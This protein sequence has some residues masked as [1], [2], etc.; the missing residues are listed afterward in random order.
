MLLNFQIV[1]LEKQ[2][3]TNELVHQSVPT[4]DTVLSQNCNFFEITEMEN[5]GYAEPDI[6]DPT[7]LD[8][9]MDSIYSN[10]LLQPE[11]NDEGEVSFHSSIQK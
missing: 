11:T 3:K 2:L 4:D 8:D 9:E 1:S 10:S 7:E 6:A 5:D